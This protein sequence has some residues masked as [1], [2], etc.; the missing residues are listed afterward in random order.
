MD[1][2]LSI[3]PQKDDH[4]SALGFSAL[5]HAMYEKNLIGLARFVKR[6]RGPPVMLGLIPHIT[7]ERELIYGYMVASSLPS[8]DYQFVFHTLMTHEIYLLAAAV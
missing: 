6:I 8:W 3:V 5:A 1:E 4:A 7:A 2:T